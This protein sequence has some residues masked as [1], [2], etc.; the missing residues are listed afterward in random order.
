MKPANAS[1]G[2]APH[3]RG[4]RSSESHTRW[5]GAS[6]SSQPSPGSATEHG[7]WG[8][9]EEHSLPPAAAPPP[10]PTN[11]DEPRTGV[12][13]RFSQRSRLGA[14]VARPAPVQ[15]EPDEPARASQPAGA[16]GEWRC[17]EA[18]GQPSKERRQ[19]RNAKVTIVQLSTNGDLIRQN[20][21]DAWLPEAGD[22]VQRMSRLLAQGLGFERCRSVCLKG[23]SA[24]LTVTEAGENRVV[25]VTGPQ[26]SMANVL[27]RAGLE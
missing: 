23:A 1:P 7:G 20:G 13:R 15:A 21:P 11:R 3:A 14:H 27:R 24:V 17:L 5:T 9:C 12:V 26:R 19:R 18:W 25:A 22:F 8:R 6:T 16:S 10:E 2:G 4:R